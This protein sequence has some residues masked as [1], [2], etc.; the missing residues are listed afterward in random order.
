MNLQLRSLIWKLRKDWMP[1][2][3]KSLG[4]RTNE[5]RS[6]IEDQLAWVMANKESLGV[7]A[8]LAFV[9]SHR[10]EFE[11][12]KPPKA[13]PWEQHPFNLAMKL[14]ESEFTRMIDAYVARFPDEVARRNQVIAQIVA[15]EKTQTE[16]ARDERISKPAVS[17]MMK[18]FYE[19]EQKK[20]G[21]DVKL[22]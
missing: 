9:T 17:R 14:P 12:M 15:G 3:A 5:R 4:Y 10:D 6:R 20:L 11:A 7:E 8:F 19:K 1:R 22:T 2:C 18:K 16:V 13:I 21:L